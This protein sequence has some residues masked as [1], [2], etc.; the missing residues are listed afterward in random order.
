M[1]SA[2]LILVLLLCPLASA[3]AE[4]AQRIFTPDGLLS[5]DEY[6]QLEARAEEIH[7]AYGIAPYYFFDLDVTELIPYTEQFAAD[8]VAEADAIVLGLSASQYYFL[9]IGTTA[10]SVFTGDVCDNT[11]YPPYNEVRN[12]P[13]SKILAYLNAVDQVLAGALTQGETAEPDA[14]DGVKRYAVDQMGLLLPADLERLNTRL[15]EISETYRCD[16]VAAI[17][18]SL[19]HKTAEEFADDYFDYGGYGYNAV[20]DANGTTVDGD[21]ILLL[22]SMEERDFAISTSGY[23]ITA[24]TDYGIQQYIEPSVL[25]YLRQNKYR[26]AFNAYADRCEELLQLAREGRPY[27]CNRVYTPDGTLTDSQWLTANERIARLY[28][29]HG[30]ITYFVYDPDV[31]D[32]SGAVDRLQNENRILE[33]NAVVFCANT[34]DHLFRTIGRIDASKFTE[35]DRQAIVDAVM[36]RL[37]SGDVYGAVSAYVDR[38]ETIL[39]RRPLNGFLVFLALT[40][41]GLFAFIPVGAMKRQLTDVHQSVNADAYLTPKSFLLTQNSDVLIGT[42]TSRAVH[43]VQATSGS[44]RAGSSGS[45]HSGSSTHTSSSGGTH[46]GHSGKF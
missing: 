9:A 38:S 12:D 41:G 33:P 22:L 28:D 36:P 40:A 26:E 42:R 11:V 31:T 29:K 5:A 6:A 19:G 32:L 35:K 30:V 23:G 3:R 44:G 34:T 37:K 27:D 20:P 16:V 21:G 39:N 24:F 14:N 2:L 13:Y 8:Y 45:F 43:V 10:K 4:D 18:Q 15:Q 7:A 25:P 1:L 46:G 17:V